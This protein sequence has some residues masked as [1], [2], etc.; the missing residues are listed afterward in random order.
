MLDN[1]AGVLTL[2]VTIHQPLGSRSRLCICCYIVIATASVSLY[3]LQVNLVT[4]SGK[5]IKTVS[6][7]Y[8]YG[9]LHPTPWIST[10][11]NTLDLRVDLTF[12]RLPS[13]HASLELHVCHLTPSFPPDIVTEGGSQ[14]AMFTMVISLNDKPY[15]RTGYGL[16]SILKYRR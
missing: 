2:V 15:I 10:V 5:K 16:P 9:S 7:R 3:P 4:C 1:S 14:C 6:S 13:W 11:S 12:T 8:H